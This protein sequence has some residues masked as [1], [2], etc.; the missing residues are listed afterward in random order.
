MQLKIGLVTGEYPPMEGGV[1]SFTQELARAIARH[2][3][4]VHIITSLQARG[5]DS[6]RRIWSPHEPI[7]V[8]YAWL[9]PRINRW[10]WSAV[11]AIANIA[12]EQELQIVNLQ[13]Q[14]AAYDMKIPALNALAWRL[15]GVSK[16]VVTFHDLRFPY[17]FPKAGRLRPWIVNR[18]AKSADGVIVTNDEDKEQLL[19][20]GVKS[21][22][23]V[24]IPIGSN[25]RADNVSSQVEI[26]ALRDELGLYEGQI[27]LGYFGFLNASKGADILLQALAKL[28]NNTHLIFLGASMGSSDPE[29]KNFL[30]HIQQLIHDFQLDSRIH[31]SGFQEDSTLSTFFQAADMM[32]MPYRDGVSLRR[33]TLMAILAHGRPLITTRS[34]GKILE[35][36]HGQ[37]VWLSP[38]DDIGALSDAIRK[39][40]IDEA[41]RNQLALGAKQLSR[42][43]SWEKIA[44]KTLDFYSR[45]LIRTE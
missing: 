27:L 45:V 18:L 15:H 24:R 43:F 1:G 9:H 7:N 34:K 33:G 41:L 31:W 32:V 39:L 5:Q 13:F 21:I 17:L 10:H 6:K 8:G 20:A 19:D 37:N 35:L 14:A 22:D 26:D 11:A 28:D 25:I 30:A 3:H 36:I 29:N 12:L 44:E 40:S 42:S 16:T 2:G 23:L 38:I 4:E